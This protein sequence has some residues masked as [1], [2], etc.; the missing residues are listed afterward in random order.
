[1]ESE[2]VF[3]VDFFKSLGLQIKKTRLSKGF[4]L[5]QLG[6]EIGLDKSAMFHIEK[7]RPIT[8]TTFLKITLALK[9]DPKD[10]LPK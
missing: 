8:M 10:L 4:T 5:E 2:E 1:M 3:I 7:G 6:F 9:I